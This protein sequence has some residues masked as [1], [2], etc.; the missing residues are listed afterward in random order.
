MTLND[1]NKRDDFKVA[2]KTFCKS[3]AGK[4][5]KEVLINLGAPAP[6]MPPAGID[7]IDWNATLNTRREGYFEALRV[8]NSLGDDFVKQESL[9]EPWETTKET[10]NQ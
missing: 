4:A 6:T 1:W 8:M 3:E 2:W 5:L 7:F 10:N 9:P